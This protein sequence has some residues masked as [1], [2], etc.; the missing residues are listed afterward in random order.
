MRTVPKAIFP[1]SLADVSHDAETVLDRVDGIRTVSD[2][3]ASLGRT[4][5]V[6]WRALDELAEAGLIAPLAPPAGTAPLRRR[7]LL[8]GALLAGGALGLATAAPALAAA[9]HEQKQGEK[10]SKL[11]VKSA[12]AKTKQSVKAEEQHHKKTAKEEAEK[13]SAADSKTQLQAKEQAKKTS[14]QEQKQK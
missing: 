5:D 12:E 8:T 3:A 1:K 10:K 11:E 4:D 7:Q 9:E 14:A 6:V 2:I 13:R